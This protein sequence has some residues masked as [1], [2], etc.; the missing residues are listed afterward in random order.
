M[1]IYTMLNHMACS[2]MQLLS[3]FSSGRGMV[4]HPADFAMKSRETAELLYMLQAT[5][6][7]ARDN[8]KSSVQSLLYRLV[9]LSAVR[10]TSHLRL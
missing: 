5:L 2:H 7:T 6:A 9:L 8:T 3:G 4:S 1:A 10:R